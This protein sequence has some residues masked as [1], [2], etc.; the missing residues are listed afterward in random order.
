M[1]TLDPSWRDRKDIPNDI[2][3]WLEATQPTQICTAQ[4]FLV[5]KFDDET[6]TADFISTML[7]ENPYVLD[8]MY[9]PHPT[10]DTHVFPRKT[11]IRA[12]YEPDNDI[13]ELYI[14]D[15]KARHLDKGN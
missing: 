3:E 9:I 12:D 15:R 4:V 13:H 5:M 10:I 6:Y 2:R 8:W 11:E 1:T 14:K 7:S